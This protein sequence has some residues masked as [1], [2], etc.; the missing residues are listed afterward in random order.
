VTVLL[1]AV[2]CDSDGDGP[3]AAPTSS[4]SAAGSPTPALTGDPQDDA[5]RLTLTDSRFTPASVTVPA[6]AVA[7]DLVNDGLLEHT[8]TMDEPQLDA[9]VPPGGAAQVLVSLGDL[10][11]AEFY[12]RFHRDAGMVGTLRVSP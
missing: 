7:V 3:D 6:Q 4:A 11:E 9:V 12:C 1:A 10:T 2:G 8:F 5:V